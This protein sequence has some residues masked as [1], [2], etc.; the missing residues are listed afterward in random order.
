MEPLATSWASLFVA[1][2][3]Y[4]IKWGEI[5]IAVAVASKLL[6]FL[7][8]PPPPPLPLLP[9]LLPP[10]N[11]TRDL[12]R[13]QDDLTKLAEGK[14]MPFVLDGKDV[15]DLPGAGQHY[16]A[17]CA[18]LF[19]D[20]PT[21][22][23][24]VRTKDHK[25]QARRVA[26]PQVGGEFVRPPTSCH[27]CDDDRGSCCAVSTGVCVCRTTTIATAGAQPGAVGPL[28]HNTHRG[29]L[30]SCLPPP[31]YKQYTQAEANLGAG[32]S[33]TAK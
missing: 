31:A 29:L 30:V 3:V 13:I 6:T 18:R 5:L 1:L 14:A 15:L 12:D 19:V 8:S 27:R 32:M 4:C 22:A 10:Q 24:H 21:L 2:E 26:E 28:L 33:A 16:C 11:R 9:L 23:L 7:L 25:K 20:A 17:S